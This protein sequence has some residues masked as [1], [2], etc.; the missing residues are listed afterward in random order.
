MMKA[1]VFHAIGDVRL[2]EVPEPTL[3]E[4][5]DAIVRLT[6]SAICGTDLHFV[7]GTFTGLEKGQILGHEGVGI[8]ERVGPQV[9]NIRVGQRVIVP[10]TVGCGECQF[11]R[12]GFFAQCDTAN[13]AG[14]LGGTV[15]FGGPVATGNLPGLQAEKARV[16]YADTGL[17]P[18]PDG[19]SDD[20]A[21]LLSDILPTAW[22][23]TELAE[24]KDT[25]HVLIF[26]C[27]PVGQLAIA[28]AK[29]KGGK[30]IAVDRLPDRLAMAKRQGAQVIDFDEVDVAKAVL[31]LT[32]GD[33]AAHVIDLVGVDAQ[34]PQHGPGAPGL[35]Q[36]A[37]EAVGQL[38]VEPQAHTH[39]KHFVA[40]DHPTQVLEWAVTCAAKAGTIAIVG[41]YPPTIQ[42]YP[43]GTAINKNLTIRMGICNHRR[44][45]EVLIE[46]ILAGRLEPT[47]VLTQFEPMTD[48][49][50]AYK[51]FDQRQP[52][53][54][55]VELEPTGR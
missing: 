1:V 52:G 42:S 31:E 5:K 23:G 15:F 27:G 20:D 51:A 53:W 26:G 4:P 9:K 19:I 55:K 16:P 21:I 22:F 11:C 8:V 29:L 40:G 54:M 6:V 32:N 24:V 2:D 39:G 12:K 35:R 28:C 14:K 41:V 44:Y 18:I 50:G 17:V 25:G 47:K 49:I 30:V 46:H 45:M 43:I 34:H 7:R 36:K 38:L 13:P 33:G 3:T 48:V 37:K 10:S